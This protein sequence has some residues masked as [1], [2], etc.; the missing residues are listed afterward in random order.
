M[1]EDGELINLDRVLSIRSEY[2]KVLN[3]RTI[4]F[5][6]EF[7]DFD[8]KNEYKKETTDYEY[9]RLLKAIGVQEKED[10]YVKN[11]DIIA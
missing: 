9:K 5:V 6:C 10:Y 8:S 2:N 4:T 3:S 1:C 11:I 7:D